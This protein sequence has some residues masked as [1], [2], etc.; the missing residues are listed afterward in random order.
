MSDYFGKDYLKFLFISRRTAFAPRRTDQ[1]PRRYRR[2]YPR[3]YRIKYPKRYNNVQRRTNRRKVIEERELVKKL[4]K[5]SNELYLIAQMKSHYSMSEMN[6]ILGSRGIFDFQ[7][8]EQDGKNIQFFRIFL[9]GIWIED[10]HM[11]NDIVKELILCDQEKY[12]WF[13]NWTE[14]SI[15]LEN[16]GMKNFKN[17]KRKLDKD[18]SIEDEWDAV[19]KGAVEHS[20]WD[21]DENNKN[22]KNNVQYSSFINEYYKNLFMK[23]EMNSSDMND[24]KYS[25]CFIVN[26]YLSKNKLRKMINMNKKYYTD[27]VFHL[28]YGK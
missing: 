22:N 24:Y 16:K 26:K 13:K 7:I 6:K 21:Y 15:A 9:E 1:Y 2:K 3:K 25:E 5:D 8:K 23:N 11:L 20:E 18:I 4:L 10:I 27:S 19:V 17:K 12:Y 28:I 14:W